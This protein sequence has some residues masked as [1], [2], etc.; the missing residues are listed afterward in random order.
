MDDTPV[1]LWITDNASDATPK[2]RLFMSEFCTLR[3]AHK[4]ADQLDALIGS[5]DWYAIFI[6][7][8]YLSIDDLRLISHVQTR[9]RCPRVALITAR[10]STDLSIWA[11]QNGIRQMGL[12]SMGRTDARQLAQAMA[13]GTELEGAT[14]APADAKRAEM[15]L[16][17]RLQ[18]RQLSTQKLHAVKM[19][20]EK[21]YQ[22]G[23]SGVEGA[24]LLRCSE[25]YFSRQ[26]AAEFGEHFARY[27][28]RY[29]IERAQ[30][31]LSIPSVSI[32][33]VASVVGFTDPS[34]FSR[35]F[36]DLTGMTPTQYRE[37]AQANGAGDPPPDVVV[38]DA[39]S[40]AL[41]AT[42]TRA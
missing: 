37:Q 35:V 26:F 6:A 13:Q 4:F 33:D 12:K 10:P 42:G 2:A 19:R 28:M 22:D 17:S 29:R 20:F 7:I 9:H 25:S 3:V 39:T 5:T 23:I 40:H 15:P 24:Q 16:E 27:K 8:D 11:M 18:A 41:G 38:A 1:A 34:Y 30:E 32:A 36:R 21:Q 14:H 31:L